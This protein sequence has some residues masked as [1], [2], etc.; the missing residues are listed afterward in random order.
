MIVYGDDPVDNS[1]AFEWLHLDDKRD[2]SDKLTKCQRAILEFFV[3]KMRF[4]SQKKMKH[5]AL[6]SPLASYS[7]G[8][9][10]NP[11]SHPLHGTGCCMKTMWSV[12]DNFFES[13]TAALNDVVTNQF[14]VSI[15]FDNWQQNNKKSGKHMVI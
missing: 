10:A 3:A 2:D 7:H 6:I 11:P 15:V 8:H 1:S 12:L 13:S 14:T 5:L 9:M 4:R